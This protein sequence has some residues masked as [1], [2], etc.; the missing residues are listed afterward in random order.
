[1]KN[2]D[3][4]TKVQIERNKKMYVAMSG[5]VDSSVAAALLKKQ[6]H[7]VVGVF[8]KPWAPQNMSGAFCNWKEDRE[9]A[10]RVA[11]KIGIPFKTWDFSKE[12]GKEVVGYMVKGYKRG[13]TPNP[14]VMCNKEIKFG[15]FLKRALSEG[16]DYIATGH[17][18]R[19]SEIKK[20][21]KRYKLLKGIDDNKDQS[22][23]LWTLSQN[24]LKHCLFP[25]GDYTK[26]EIRKMA[27]KFGL[28]NHDKKDSQGVCFVGKM[29]VKDF[30]TTQI[31]SKPGD[32]ILKETGKIIGTHDGVYY[33]TIGQRHGLNL[34][35][36]G[37]P[38]FVVGKDVKKNAIHVSGDRVFNKKFTANS[39][40]WVNE[41]DIA[42]A[43]KPVKLSIKIRYRNKSVPALVSK[44]RKKN[45]ANIEFL[46][47][48][49]DIT[50]GQSAVFYKGQEMV[51]GGIIENIK[52]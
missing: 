46:K 36:A 16:A 1:M 39:L 45:S 20:P 24:Q 18:V 41:H 44:S 48:V 21:N 5:G 43:K 12:Y 42:S 26:P 28:P 30:L 50:I 29:D 6:G 22:Y 47:P 7:D 40:N 11:A 8:F 49:S 35:I 9:D 51:G 17:Y 32:V 13:E 19:R 37:G 31:K 2:R 23:F 27:K 4:T 52:Q 15:L 38:Y 34:G 25:V 33:Y 3:K 14:D 10:M